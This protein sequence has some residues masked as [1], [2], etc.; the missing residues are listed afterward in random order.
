MGM[1]EEGEFWIYFVGLF[2]RNVENCFLVRMG[3]WVIGN[4]Y[5]LVDVYSY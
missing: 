4:V 1:W 5:G 2:F 3:I